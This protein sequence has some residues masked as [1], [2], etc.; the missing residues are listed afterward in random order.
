M[1]NEPAVLSN[2]DPAA[3][4][5]ELAALETEAQSKLADAKGKQHI[6][7]PTSP[8]S[9]TLLAANGTIGVGVVARLIGF[10]RH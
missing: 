8:W 6:G 7:P 9:G 4:G 1:T 2:F 10:R 5:D 3:I